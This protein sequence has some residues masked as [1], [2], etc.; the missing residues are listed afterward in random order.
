M[1]RPT[2]PI[3]LEHPGE[4]RVPGQTH[5]VLEARFRLASNQEEFRAALALCHLGSSIQ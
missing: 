4:S 1:D 2:L 5:S 3:D